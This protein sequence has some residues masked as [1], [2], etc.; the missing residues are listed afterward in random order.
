MAKKSSETPV[1]KEAATEWV[2]IDDLH[3]WEGNY[4][5]GD[6]GAIITSLKEFGYNRSIAVWNGKVMAGN[7]T[8]MAMH[9]LRDQGYDLKGNIR[10]GGDGR[11]EI[12]VSDLSH[13]NEEQAVAYAVADN[14]TGELASP[15][16]RRLADILKPM[17]ERNMAM[18]RATGH[19]EDDLN[20]L[21]S[22]VKRLNTSQENRGDKS[23]QMDASASYQGKWK[24]QLGDLWEIP[25]ETAH[26]SHWLMCGDSMS[27][28]DVAVVT[29]GENPIICITDPPY[30]VNYDPSWRRKVLGSSVQ[31]GKVTSD[32]IADW[33]PAL[34]M[35]KPDV[36]YVWHAAVRVAEVLE[37]LFA[38]DYQLRSIIIWDKN[39]FAISQGHYHWAHEPCLYLVRKGAQA[40]WQGDRSQTTMWRVGNRSSV[41]PSANPDHEDAFKSDHGTQKPVELYRRPILNHMREGQWLYEPFSGSGSGFIAAESESRLCRGMEVMPE[42]CA[43]I[44]E[45]LSTLGLK[46]KRV[47]DAEA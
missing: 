14:R 7:H 10:K 41:A 40:H 46:P 20:E 47:G 24:V 19:D 16:I 17:A 44:L 8:F 25:S 6:I 11:W 33:S 9:Q 29:K 13:L 5:E 18:F 32:D 2:S 4:N 26:G 12:L 30:G 38:A 37:P 45:R 15:N 34:V 27:P 21:L 42:Y 31:E 43:S 36:L 39:G 28:E 3:G 1:A 22:R 23:N 35:T